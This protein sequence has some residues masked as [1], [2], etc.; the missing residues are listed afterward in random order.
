MSKTDQERARRLAEKLRDN[1][2]RRKTQA[3]EAEGQGPKSPD[4]D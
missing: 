4:Q 3:R 2:R 1:L